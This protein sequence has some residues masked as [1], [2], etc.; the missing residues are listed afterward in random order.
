MEAGELARILLK[1]RRRDND[2]GL[3]A[4]VGIPDYRASALLS[5]EVDTERFEASLFVSSCQVL[6]LN[7]VLSLVIFKHTIAYCNCL[8]CRLI[9]YDASHLNRKSIV[10]HIFNLVIFHHNI[11][12]IRYLLC[13]LLP[14]YLLGTC[15]V[16]VKCG[17]L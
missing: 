11:A 4:I 2:Q 17:T 5:A 16:G 12:Y 3:T 7:Q 1:S 14:I 13:K 6:R 8:L 9:C 15:Y 10:R